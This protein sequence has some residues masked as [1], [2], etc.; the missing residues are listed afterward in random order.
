MRERFTSH[1]RLRCVSTHRALGQ[2]NRFPSM[3]EIDVSRHI[4]L[5]VSKSVPSMP[6]ML[7]IQRPLRRVS[8]HRAL[9]QAI[10]RERFTF[11]AAFDVSRHIALSVRQIGA[12]HT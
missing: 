5:S 11:I 8:T 12:I 9:G 6:E 4:A 10:E 7:H 1:R 3:R 2:A